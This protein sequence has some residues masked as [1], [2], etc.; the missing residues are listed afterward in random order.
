MKVRNYETIFREN[1]STVSSI[2]GLFEFLRDYLRLVK[3]TKRIR[4]QGIERLSAREEG[5][6]MNQLKQHLEKK[7]YFGN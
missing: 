7:N 5:F 4:I 2:G 6:A 1:N 3:F